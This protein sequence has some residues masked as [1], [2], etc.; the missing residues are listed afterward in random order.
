MTFDI[1]IATRNRSKRLVRLVQQILEC[2][3]L[4]QRIVI[5]DSSDEVD[6]DI[7]RFPGIVYR[8]TRFRNQPYQRYLGYK[9]TESELV[10]F[11]DDDVEIVD[12]N[13][14]DK[15]IY[16]YVSPSVVGVTVGIDYRNVVSEGVSI[17]SQHPRTGW[18]VLAFLKIITGVPLLKVG[19]IGL[20]GLVGGIPIGFSG[21]VFYFQ[22]A[23]MSFRRRILEKLFDTTVFDLYEAGLGKGEDK[24]LSMRA[25]EFGIL[26]SVGDL[27][28]RHPPTDSHY[29]N[30]VVQF[31][32]R[33]FFSR[34]YLSKVYCEVFRVPWACAILHYYWFVVWRTFFSILKI[35]VGRTREVSSLRGQW[36]GIIA[37]TRFL[38]NK[39]QFK[40]NYAWFQNLN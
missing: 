32:R 9:L 10:V 20:A 8:H 15:F 12:S 30:G 16:P 1:V 26:Y 39:R 22:G 7:C 34:I 38:L 35:L 5:V 36:R 14:F 19:E 17:R 37:A 23:N 21:R 18:T 31:Q 40:S 4:P 27:C 24:M 6:G 3:R 33:S 2:T 25:N 13:C 29:F 11:L 28:L